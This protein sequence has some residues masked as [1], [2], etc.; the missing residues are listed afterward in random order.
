MAGLTV[1]SWFAR[2]MNRLTSGILR[3]AGSG[4]VMTGELDLDGHGPVVARFGLRRLMFLLWRWHDAG[5]T[6]DVATNHPLY[7]VG[8]STLWGPRGKLAPRWLY[9]GQYGGIPR[10][11]SPAPANGAANVGLDLY[12]QVQAP[13]TPWPLLPC[14]G[15]SKARS[16][17][18][19]RRSRV[20]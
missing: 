2:L 4:S 17:A 15:I 20:V 3:A 10:V 16:N 5:R 6:S 11:A 14:L 8:A 19:C 1:R 18:P 9:G 7:R 12:L 13:V